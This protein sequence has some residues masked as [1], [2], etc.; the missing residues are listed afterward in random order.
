M[1]GEKVTR[2]LGT[3]I[4]GQ[5]YC[6]SIIKHRRN[7]PN[8]ARGDAFHS[9]I[10]PF[11]WNSPDTE[12]VNDLWAAATVW[13]TGDHEA[14]KSSS[15]VSSQSSILGCLE[16]RGDHAQYRDPRNAVNRTAKYY[17]RALHL[18]MPPGLANPTAILST[19]HDLRRLENRY[20]MLPGTYGAT[21]V[22]SVDAAC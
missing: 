13:S 21:S 22:A 2:C 17:A 18:G 14:I 4:R 19:L 9:N 3:H 12:Y 6:A 5:L 15:V 7:T 1:T 16:V 8:P 11:F 20:C 10:R